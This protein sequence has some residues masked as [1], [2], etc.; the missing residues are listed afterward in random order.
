MT[1]TTAADVCPHCGCR[2]RPARPSRERD[3][4]RRA[5][6][7]VVREL[8][9]ATAKQ[10]SAALKKAHG[11]GTVTKALADLTRAGRLVNRSDKRG[12]RVAEGGRA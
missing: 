7:I 8:G 4:C 1:S 10:V 6:V 2:P 3:G 11:R 12:Y 5:V 9:E